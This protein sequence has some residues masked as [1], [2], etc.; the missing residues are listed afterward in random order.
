MFKI[1]FQTQLS[2][3]MVKTFQEQGTDFYEAVEPIDFKPL[4]GK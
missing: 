1:L 3:A 4:K 2:S